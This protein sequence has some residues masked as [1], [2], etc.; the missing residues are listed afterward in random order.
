MSS[1]KSSVWLELVD[2]AL[3][4]HERG[5]M[6]KF[7]EII[8][9]LRMSIEWD[10][11]TE[12]T[13]PL[14]VENLSSDG[15]EIEQEEN[16]YFSTISQLFQLSWEE[17]C[18]GNYQSARNHLNDI[19]D[20]LD[21]IQEV[22]RYGVDYVNAMAVN[23]SFGDIFYLESEES[24]SISRKKELRKSSL[25]CFTKAYENIDWYQ[26]SSFPQN[27][28]DCR[29]KMGILKGYKNDFEGQQKLFTEALEIVRKSDKSIIEQYELAL[30]TDLTWLATQNKPI[31]ETQVIT[32]DTV[33]VLKKISSPS[34]T[35]PENSGRFIPQNELQ[36]LNIREKLKKYND[37]ARA[38]SVSS[39]SMYLSEFEYIPKKKM[40]NAL[41][42]ARSIGLGDRA[43][44]GENDVIAL[45]DTSI[46]GS[47]KSYVIFTEDRLIWKGT[48]FNRCRFKKYSDIDNSIYPKEAKKNYNVAIGP[49]GYFDEIFVFAPTLPLFV[50]LLSSICEDE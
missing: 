17:K 20:F 10:T 35:I 4:A 1:D 34:E 43:P 5:D 18:A 47:A 28:I 11:L 41:K 6:D 36:G 22:Q 27:T 33:Q 13:S 42:R 23:F 8:E 7:H 39:W 31:E 12:T 44:I 9:H 3:L 2:E 49:G 48:P 45:L 37:F 21:P 16:E 15:I 25:E 14:I 32:D 46:F 26:G 30:V 29:V 38:L 50:E 19:L 40:K 24:E